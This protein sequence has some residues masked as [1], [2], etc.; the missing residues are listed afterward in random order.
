MCTLV[1]RWKDKAYTSNEHKSQYFSKFGTKI[2]FLCL[3][4]T[5]AEK[6]LKILIVMMKAAKWSF[7]NFGKADNIWFASY[8]KQK[9]VLTV[10]S[11]YDIVY[12]RLNIVR[13]T[14]W[15]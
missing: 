10:C 15:L 3:S 12:V 7:L 4:K 9:R 1:S 8:L 2:S 13:E 6:D 5:A 14:Q 11:Q